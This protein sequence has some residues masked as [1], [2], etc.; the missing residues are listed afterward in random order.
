MKLEKEQKQ[1]SGEIQ[2]GKTEYGI[3]EY[4][5]PEEEQK[6][7]LIHFKKK[8]NTSTHIPTKKRKF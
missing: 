1:L 4:G 8:K 3:T 5:K 2:Y 7:F 6:H